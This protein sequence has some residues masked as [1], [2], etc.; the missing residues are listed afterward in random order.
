METELRNGTAAA[1]AA[2]DWT[3][4]TCDA[5]FHRT[6]VNLG[7]RGVAMATHFHEE[8]AL[9]LSLAQ[10]WIWDIPVIYL[11]E[12]ERPLHMNTLIRAFAPKLKRVSL[13]PGE[14]KRD[15]MGRTARELKLHGIF[16]GLHRYQNPERAGFPM[17]ELQRYREWEYVDIHPVIDW[18]PEMV[19]AY[20]EQQKLPRPKNHKPGTRIQPENCSLHK[21]RVQ[22]A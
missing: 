6:V 11:V 18:T 15:A 13:L 5:V 14:T 16:Y 21:R 7:A 22:T 20:F 1:F 3:G 4:A 10:R 17:V 8:S 19:A 9:M 12:S 2:E